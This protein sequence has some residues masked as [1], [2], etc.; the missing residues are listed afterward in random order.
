MRR[1]ATWKNPAVLS[2]FLTPESTFHQKGAHHQPLPGSLLSL[3]FPPLLPPVR[4]AGPGMTQGGP[5][6]R[7]LSKKGGRE[8]HSKERREAAPLERE[9]VEGSTPPPAPHQGRM[10]NQHRPGGGGG[11]PLYFTFL[12]FTSVTCVESNFTHFVFF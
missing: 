4:H 10:G 11:P 6:N 5:N 2:H 1:C 7:H 9:R 12:H 8:H 3:L